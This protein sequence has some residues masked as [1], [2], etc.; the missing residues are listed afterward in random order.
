M[1]VSSS[2]PSAAVFDHAT[3]VVR[4]VPAKP[5]PPMYYQADEQWGGLPY[6]TVDGTISTHGC[7]LASAAMAASYL[8]ETEIDPPRL[9]NLVG[10]RCI[11]D[12]VN[13]MSKSCQELHDIYGLHY[14]NRLTTKDEAL[15]YVADGWIAFAGMHGQLTDDGKSYAGHVV[16][17]WRVDESGVWI[18]DPYNPALQKPL[19]FEQFSAVHFDYFYALGA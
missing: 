13:D 18:R 1:L 17:I 16:L 15:D 3:P 14:S 19:T 6:A 9:L 8:T 5:E 10:N 2:Q 4:D 11:S 7:G 12:D